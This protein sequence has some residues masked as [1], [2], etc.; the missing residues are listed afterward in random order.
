MKPDDGC[1]LVSAFDALK[2]QVVLKPTPAENVDWQKVHD[3][4]TGPDK[5]TISVTALEGRKDLPQFIEKQFSA[6]M[7]TPSCYKGASKPTR[8]VLVL[9]HGL[10]FPEGSHK[11][12]I[13]KCDCKVFYLRQN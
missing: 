1:V 11:I 9:T 10:Q 13:D 3:V 7:T 6:L 5:D 12:K 8:I 4:E 2:D